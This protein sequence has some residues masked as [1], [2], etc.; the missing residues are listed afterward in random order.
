[1][2]ISEYQTLR[3]FSREDI[4]P[5]GLLTIRR[6]DESE[7]LIDLTP[8]IDRVTAYAEEHDTFSLPRELQEYDVGE[9]RLQFDAIYFTR[10]ADGEINYFDTNGFALMR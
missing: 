1:M 9:Y 2:D 6:A 10:A 5:E 3:R 4:T 8:Y 7:E